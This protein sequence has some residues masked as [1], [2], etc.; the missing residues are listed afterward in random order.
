[1]ADY[2][3]ECWNK[4]TL[5]VKGVLSVFQTLKD[6]SGEIRGELATQIKAAGLVGLVTTVSRV[7]YRI[8]AVFKGFS[9]ALSNAFA[10]IDVIFV[11]VSYT[12]L[13]IGKRTN[14]EDMLGTGP[15]VEHVRD[16]LV[17]GGQEPVI[18]AVPVQGQQ[19]GY[20]SDAVVTGSEVTPQVSGVAAKNADIVVKVET[21]GA[22]GTA[23]L[24]ISTDGGKTFGEASPS[25][26]QV[27]I[28]TS[29]DATGATLVFPCLLYTSGRKRG[30]GVRGPAAHQG[31]DSGISQRAERLA[32]AFRE[33]GG[34]DGL[35]H[36]QGG[37]DSPDRAQ[38]R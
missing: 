30:H 14:L 35:A 17:T 25:S 33:Q 2:L 4:I 7:V 37:S 28:G 11:P 18:V 8:Q 34:A 16:M 29:E 3:H 24:K 10:R 22:I 6:G 27:V 38:Y 21:P 12:H 23:T 31:A 19:A 1:M 5:T 15:L 32:R 36:A 20:I 9:K 13:L 26:E